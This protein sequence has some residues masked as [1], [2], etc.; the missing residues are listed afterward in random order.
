MDHREKGLPNSP[1]DTSGSGNMPL[2]DLVSHE[3]IHGISTIATTQV[4]ADIC[5]P[6]LKERGYQIMNEIGGG[7]FSKVYRAKYK[8]M[9]DK[10]IAVKIISLDK[11]P[12]IWREKCLRTE[13]K[14]IK[15]LQHP[16]VIKVW[17]IVKTRRSVYIFMD[18][19]ENDSVLQ[20]MRSNKRPVTEMEAKLWFSQA[21]GAVAYMHNRGIAHRDLKNENILLDRDNNAKL[22]DFGFACFTY[23]KETRVPIYSATCCGT[24]A[25]IA[26][27][28]L[29]PPYDAKVS[30]VWSLGV[31]LYE[32]LS[33]AKPFD[34]S[35]SSRK[36]LNAQL[37]HQWKFP[38]AIDEKLN[39][40]VK[41]LVRKMLEPDTERR[42]TATA[43]LKH[44]WISIAKY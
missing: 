36:L 44:H 25:Y 2:H 3:D 37:K 30:D 39:D 7:A 28:V 1:S 12:E 38:S 31:C 21:A 40:A 43:I 13:L 9:G 35:L 41:D 19:A 24:M 6:A 8:P 27:E 33:N 5:P 18:L 22:T 42:L 17:D 29:N 11:V 14:I 20:F 34:E 23:D 26:P 15:K 10:E 32:M 4:A 16:N